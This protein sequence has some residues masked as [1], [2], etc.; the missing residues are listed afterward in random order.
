MNPSSRLL[1]LTTDYGT[2]DGYAGAIKG[3]VLSLAPS[4]SIHDISHQIAPQAIWE[5][6]WCLRRAVPRFPPGTTHL[7]VVDPGVGSG[8][9][10]VVIETERHLLIGPDNGVLTLAARDDGIRRVFEIDE[11]GESWH[12]SNTFDGLTLFAPVAGMLLSGMA[13][14]EVGP[15]AEDLVELTEREAVL[16][17]GAI[18]GS[19]MLFDRFGNAITDI[20]AS[21]IE[22]RQVKGVSLKEFQ[23]VRFC[24]NYGDLAGS[25]VIG[26]LVN[27]DGLLELAL[28]GASLQQRHNLEIGDPVRVQLK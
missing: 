28:F 13:L 8:R 15:E 17:D 1:T 2:R 16:Q 4:A 25:P 6:A 7:A 23:D 11:E 3:A 9:S 24:A 27:S 19:V 5:G 21:L 26:C 22:G 14:E 10:G 12:R 20:P 18:E